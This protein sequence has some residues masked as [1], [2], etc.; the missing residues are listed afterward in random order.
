MSSK[1]KHNKKRNTAFLY[2]AL[3][4]QLTKAS[5]KKDDGQKNIIISI[6]KESFQA[7]TLLAKDCQYKKRGKKTRGKNYI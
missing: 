2:E 7:G 6:L 5:I 3:V 1:I 4:R